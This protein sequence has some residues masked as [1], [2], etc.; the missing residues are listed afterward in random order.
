MISDNTIRHL[1]HSGNLL[2]IFGRVLIF[3]YAGPIRASQNG[4]LEG[5]VIDP[6][7]IRDEN[8]TVFVSHGHRDHFCPE[9]FTWQQHVKRISYVISSDITGL[10]DD[11]IQVGPGETTE[12][13]G[14]R[15][16][17]YHS[18]DRGVA[19]SV[20]INDKHIYFAGDHALW[21]RTGETDDHRYIRLMKNLLNQ[22]PLMDIAFHVC[23]PRLSGKGAGGIYAFART[24]QPTVLVPIHTFGVYKFNKKAHRELIR[25]GYDGYF[26]EIQ[27]PGEELP[28]QSSGCVK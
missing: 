25:Q 2:K 9:I 10:P 24:F 18:T 22:A 3:D 6:V 1:G 27:Y 16:K 26:W 28:I 17:T 23:D 21:N 8:V 4:P 5:S 14:L 15:I 13:G 7:E 11:I 12:T 20:F 19:F